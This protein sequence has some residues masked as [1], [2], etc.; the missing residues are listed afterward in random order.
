[1]PIALP[2]F[3]NKLTK[4]LQNAWLALHKKWKDITPYKSK[5]VHTQ[6]IVGRSELKNLVSRNV[7]EVLFLRRR[8]ERAPG[9]PEW[10]RMLCTNSL[11]V[12]NSNNG[13]VSLGFRFPKSPRRIDE[14]KHN[15]VVV[16]D[17]IMQDYRNI[18]LD[19]CYLM[20]VIPEDD[21][22][23]NYFNDVLYPMT[24]DQKQNFMDN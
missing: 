3:F 4:P 5:I 12:L 19:Q 10:R 24:A 9:R 7:C 17:I 2:T 6:R 23:W 18:S 1:M 16:Y 8:P 14:A 22:F 11:N 13:K 20:Q 15:I 21:T